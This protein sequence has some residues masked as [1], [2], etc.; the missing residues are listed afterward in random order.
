[1]AE[2]AENLWRRQI[3]YTAKRGE[4]LDRNGTAL[5]YNITTPTVMAIPVQVKE[6]EKTAEALAPLLGMTQEKVLGIISKTERIVE[7]SP[8]AEKL[9]WRKHRKFVIWSFRALL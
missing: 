3:P 9:R 6:K 7:I 4:I 1:M 2:E 8:G 5:A